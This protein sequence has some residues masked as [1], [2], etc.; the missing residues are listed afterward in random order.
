[1]QT[2]ISDGEYK[3]PPS[4]WLTGS[5]IKSFFSRL[6]R[7]KKHRSQILSDRSSENKGISDDD[8]SRVHSEIMQLPSQL[9]DPTSSETWQQ[10]ND[11]VYFPSIIRKMND[12]SVDDFIVYYPKKRATSDK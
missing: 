2:A 12:R 5:Q 6:I 1:M 10:Q 9:L 7:K 11:S 3:F 8:E 4:K